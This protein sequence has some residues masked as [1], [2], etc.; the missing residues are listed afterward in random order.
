MNSSRMH[1]ARPVDHMGE[2]S[3][4]EGSLSKER[5][6]TAYKGEG[7]CLWM[8]VFQPH[9]IVGW[10][11][12]PCEQTDTCENITFQQLHLRAVIRT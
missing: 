10:Q 5:R 12:S 6:G 9:G 7:V 3:A 11:T 8:G 4:V 2:G 1:T